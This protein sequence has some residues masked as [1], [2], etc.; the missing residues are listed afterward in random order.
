MERV[1]KRGEKKKQTPNT[2]EIEGV[3][4]GGGEYYLPKASILLLLLLPQSLRARELHDLQCAL[5]AAAQQARSTQV[6]RPK[7]PEKAIDAIAS[8]RSNDDVRPEYVCT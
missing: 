5:Q 7:T 3:A 8:G 6:N 2:W 4:G 1:R